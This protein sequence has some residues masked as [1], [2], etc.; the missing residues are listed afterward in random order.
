MTTNYYSTLYDAVP[1]QGSATGLYVPR[2]PISDTIYKPFVAKFSFTIAASTVLGTGDIIW[3]MPALPQYFHVTRACFNFPGYDGG[4]GSASLTM[5]L[6][7]ASAASGTGIV[8]GLTTASIRT[9]AVLSLTDTQILAAS[10]A[11][12]A[13]TVLTN[14]QQ[15]G[16]A[17]SLIIYVSAGAN[18]AGTNG[19]TS[20]IVEGVVETT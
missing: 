5:N 15:P 7:W 3:L 19:A 4:G 17:D 18:A 12:G 20:V 10:G 16:N 1:Y 9:G 11:A 6:G 14:S 2:G 13:A 8:T